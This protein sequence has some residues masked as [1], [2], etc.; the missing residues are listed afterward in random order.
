[1]EG[2][3]AMFSSILSIS[4]CATMLAVPDR[5]LPDAPKSPDLEATWYD[6]LQRTG[7][8][9][10]D[11][12]DGRIVISTKEIR[13]RMLIRPTIMRYDDKQQ[14]ISTSSAKEAELHFHAARRLLFMNVC[15]L[16]GFTPNG[17]EWYLES[18]I[19]P[20]ELPPVAK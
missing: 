9:A 19:W 12:K 6:Q 7:T 5:P 20:H 16:N 18:M 10:I 4:F 15:E 3:N 13:G 17:T 8:L 1:M 14:L 2:S 11:L